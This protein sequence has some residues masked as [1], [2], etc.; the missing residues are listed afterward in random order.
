MRAGILTAFFAFLALA[1]AAPAPGLDLDG[2]KKAGLIGE[3]PDGY[4]GV[5]GQPTPHV[6]ALV[7]EV[8]A[9]RRAAY[10]KIAQQ[11]GAPLADVAALAGKK[12]IEG[13]PAGAYVYIDGKWVRRE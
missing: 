5:V 6:Q 11:N 4:V 1:L 9:K 8:N 10:G 13:A 3:K 2:A 7:E 12:L